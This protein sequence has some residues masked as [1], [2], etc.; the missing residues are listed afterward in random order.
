MVGLMI[1]I[2]MMMEVAVAV[3]VTET[4]ALVNKQM[5]TG[6]HDCTL[7]NQTGGVT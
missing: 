5:N 7:S 2:I 4:T 3:T 1:I 6:K